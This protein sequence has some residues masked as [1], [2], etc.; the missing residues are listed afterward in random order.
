MANFKNQR[1]P[2]P[3]KNLSSEHAFEVDKKQVLPNEKPVN[4]SKRDSSSFKETKVLYPQGNVTIPD[5]AKTNN[6]VIQM[7][8]IEY[9]EE[10]L[11]LRP[12]SSKDTPIKIEIEEKEEPTSF[13]KSVIKPMQEVNPTLALFQQAKTSEETIKIEDT[14]EDKKPKEK[15]KKGFMRWIII[16]II[17]ELIILGI[18]F[19]IRN[20]KETSVLECSN[21]EYNSYYEATIINT[22]RYTFYKGNITKLEDTTKY[23]FDNKEAYEEYKTNYANPPHTELDGR[24]FISNINDND[25]T[26]E[27]KIN[28]DYKKLRKKNTSSDEHNIVITTSDENDTISLLDYNIT[29]IKIIYESDYVCK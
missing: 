13:T 16:G 21:E 18:L 29:D 26:Y 24:I 2:K 15:K 23:V 27:E 25:N 17:L 1:D 12:I 4:F 5:L 9:T 14:K 28:Y 10:K 6:E 8:K 3:I 19:I 20:K 7:P 11:P 22:K